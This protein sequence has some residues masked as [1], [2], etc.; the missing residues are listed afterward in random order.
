M[1]NSRF[2]EPI[3]VL[4]STKVRGGHSQGFKNN[5]QCNLSTLI[6]GDRPMVS[7]TVALGTGNPTKIRAT[8]KVYKL[9]YNKVN[10]IGIDLRAGVSVQPRE[11]GVYLGARNRA[12]GA[13]KTAGA[14]YGVG[15]EAGIVKIN[16]KKMNT[17]C[18]VIVDRKKN[19]HVGYSVMFE[20]PSKI[21]ELVDKGMDLSHAVDQ[22]TGTRDS[23]HHEGLVG[24]LSRGNFN[25]EKMLSEAVLM[26]LMEFENE[27]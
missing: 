4:S 7:I 21:M 25:R 16:G 22:F 27:K 9:F 20:I 6:S 5:A 10:V 2:A 24:I 12:Y 1:R 23:G 11:E 18:C 17:A 13:I 26:A 19:E 8:K 3:I 14:H 15:I